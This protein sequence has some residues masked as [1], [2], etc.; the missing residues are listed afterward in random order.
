MI[1]YGAGTAR[2][3]RRSASLA[4]GGR[5]FGIPSGA[6]VQLNGDGTGDD[7][8]RRPG[9]RHRLGDG[10][11]G[12]RRRGARACSPRTSRSSTRTPTAAPWDM[13]SCGLADDVQQRPCG[14]RGGDRGARA[15]ARPGGRQARGGARRPRAR[16]G[17]RARQGI[18]RTGRWRSPTSPARAAAARQGLGRGARRPR[19]RPPRDASAG[20]AWSRSSRRS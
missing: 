17:H 12:A 6:Y 15:A 8:D 5:R 1:G 3:T 7:H 4:A 11:A 16:R 10:A 9:E 14:D 20:S 19:R 2:R 13:G 18:A